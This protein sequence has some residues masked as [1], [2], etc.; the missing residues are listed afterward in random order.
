METKPSSSKTNLEFLNEIET[1]DIYAEPKHYVFL[2][3]PLK[4]MLTDAAVAKCFADIIQPSKPDT[5][6]CH[7]VN[8]EYLKHFAWKEKTLLP[9]EDSPKLVMLLTRLEAAR[10]G[11]WCQHQNVSK[12]S[13][14]EAY[15]PRLVKEFQEMAEAKYGITGGNRALYLGLG[16]LSYE[17][18]GDQYK[19]PR[20]FLG[21]PQELGVTWTSSGCQFWRKE[22]PQQTRLT[23]M[24]LQEHNLKPSNMG[25]SAAQQTQ[26]QAISGN[27]QSDMANL[28][29]GLPSPSAV[30]PR[31]LDLNIHG[32]NGQTQ[33]PMHL[34]II[35]HGLQQIFPAISVGQQITIDQPRGLKRER[36]KIVTGIKARPGHEEA[37]DPPRKRREI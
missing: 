27:I 35:Q 9:W 20:H 25:L 14:F 8:E 26:G 13:G 19:W 24:L 11:G 36:D 10:L 4:T 23:Q 6:L 7:W 18:G 22:A 17:V 1:R 16:V 34:G 29:K 32:E 30:L 5:F 2:A 31:V 3:W 37:Q 33:V 28:R 15:T 12:A 21:C